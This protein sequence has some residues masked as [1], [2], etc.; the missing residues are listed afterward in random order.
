M[1]RAQTKRRPRGP[2]SSATPAGMRPFLRVWWERAGKPVAGPVFPVRRGPR[3]GK[4]KKG[5]GTSF[6]GRMRR[7][8]FRAGVWRLP[9]VT[10][11]DSK[12]A[13]NA[14]DPF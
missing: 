2:V 1:R 11:G 14:V 12:L 7:D 13:P 6:A 3:A 9:P 8:F 5:R 10:T 4:D